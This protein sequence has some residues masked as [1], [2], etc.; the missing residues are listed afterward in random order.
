[1]KRA[2]IVV[3]YQHDFVDGSLGFE[4]AKLLEQPICD[5]IAQTRA[6]GG[7]VLFTLDT[8]G[9]EYLETREGSDLPVP[10]CLKGTPGWKLY[11]KVGDH[12]AESDRVFEKG[13][14]GSLELAACLREGGYDAVE[15]V[16]LVSNICVLSN[17]LLAKA[18]LPE[19]VVTVDASCTAC[20]DPD[21]NQ[22]ALDVMR[23]SFVV[24]T[25]TPVL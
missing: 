20:A 22:K 16:G 21:V 1:M 4:A 25:G 8:H 13:A 14:F 5:K 23:S 3:D 10:H 2:L 11:G 12:L 9:P 24:I 17:A 18:A 15:L 7:D 6:Q 19:A